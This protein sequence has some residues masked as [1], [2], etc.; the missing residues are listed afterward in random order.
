MENAVIVASYSTVKRVCQE[1]YL[2]FHHLY[3]LFSDLMFL[4]VKNTMFHFT[5]TSVTF[6]NFLIFDDFSQTWWFVAEVV[7]G[8][9]GLL[10]GA[11]YLVP[12]GSRTTDL[13]QSTARAHIT[14]LARNVLFLPESCVGA[15]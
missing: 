15:V 3:L 8:C 1:I 4:G 6:V 5:W 13:M 7:L 12:K 2:K 11:Q 14:R 9:F 10:R